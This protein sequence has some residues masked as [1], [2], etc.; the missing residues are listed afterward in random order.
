MRQRFL[1]IFLLLFPAVVAAQVT[2][3][4]TDALS[5]DYDNAIYQ[6]WTVTKFESQYDGG[7]WQPLVIA[8]FT[9]SSTLVNHTSYRFIPPFTAGNH[10]VSL[11]ACNAVGCGTASAPFAFGYAV[12]SAP[13]ASPVNVR[14][15]AR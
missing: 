6:Q 15:V 14:K 10:T 8:Q 5:F 13:T 2:L 7:T 3:T 9:D 1:I 4:P 11:R 12:S